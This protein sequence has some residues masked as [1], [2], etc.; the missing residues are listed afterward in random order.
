MAYF[1]NE[2]QALQNA[3]NSLNIEG[4]TIHERQPNDKRKT[5]K[6]Y[7]L[8][9]GSRTISPNLDYIQMNH[10]ILGMNRMKDI[11]SHS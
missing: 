9:H 7:F 8:Q 2:L 5:V 1:I 10:F 11:Y 4:L 6:K 3:A